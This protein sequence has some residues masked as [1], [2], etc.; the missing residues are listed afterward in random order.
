MGAALFC[1]SE[2]Y[3]MSVRVRMC[4]HVCAVQVYTNVCRRVRGACVACPTPIAGRWLMVDHGFHEAVSQ[5]VFM[6]GRFC[7]LSAF[8]WLFSDK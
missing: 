3:Q 7:L 5:S 4:T 1:Q 2:A 8:A 6:L